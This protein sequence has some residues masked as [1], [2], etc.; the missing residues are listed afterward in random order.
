MPNPDISKLFSIPALLGDSAETRKLRVACQAALA[1]SSPALIVV[2]EGFD[3]AVIA[4]AL[5]TASRPGAPFEILSPA[6]SDPPQVELA[7]FGTRQRPRADGVEVLGA[8]GALL[9][10]AGGTLFVD[11]VGDLPAMVQ[12]RL[13][14]LLRDGEARAGGRTPAPLKARV[15]AA[16]SP[17]IHADVQDG[18]V[19]GD[20][21]RRLAVHELV[22]PPL[23]GRPSDFA[24]LV[25]A[26]VAA[27]SA[28]R[29]RSAPSFT[30]SALTV[31]AA[32]PWGRNMAELEGL[33]E[34][35]LDA[36]PGNSVKQEDVL[37]Q[38]SFDG[39]FARRAPAPS[40]R[41]ARQRFERD[42][43]AAVLEH[44]QWRMSDAA[45]ALGIERANLYRKT[46][47]LG[48]SRARAAQA[49]AHR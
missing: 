24:S 30:Q 37:A 6:Q 8:G 26:V 20:L 34:R 21:Y 35:I 19:L 39:A 32:L 3:P 17:G 16:A 18:R 28:R 36:V 47:Q 10:A 33:I 43:I 38:L 5:H 15:V 44:H 45:R 27:T 48:I 22:V 41:E 7:L 1:D 46:R 12:R 4:R 14:R 23:R 13:A 42:Y 49:A 40:L 9:R 25:P 31:L 2:E 11:S 29:G